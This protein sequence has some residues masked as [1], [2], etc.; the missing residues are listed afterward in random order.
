MSANIA[1]WFFL[2]GYLGGVVAPM[3][4]FTVKIGRKPATHNQ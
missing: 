2:I 4:W 1:K 3:C